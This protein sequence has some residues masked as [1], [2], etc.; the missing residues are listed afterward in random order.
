MLAR[1]FRLCLT[2]TV[3]IGVGA[4][5]DFVAEV[6]ELAGVDAS[7]LLEGKNSRLP[8]YSRSV[9][10]N[11]LTSKRVFIFG[12]ATHAVSAA[13]IASQELGFTVA[14]LGTYSREFAREVRKSP[15]RLLLAPKR[16][17]VEDEQ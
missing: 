3:P 9:D 8:W 17:K 14:G 7:Q 13:R 6:A 15:N 1:Y 5:R 2:R 11:Y 12:D 10:S 16:D 4:T